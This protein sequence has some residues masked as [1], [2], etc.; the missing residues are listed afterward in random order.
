MFLE[1][2]N[3]PK[4]MTLGSAKNQEF[5]SKRILVAPLPLQGSLFSN[6]DS[7]WGDLL[8]SKVT[9]KSEFGLLFCKTFSS[10]SE[11]PSGGSPGYI[12]GISGIYPRDPWDISWG[13]L[14]VS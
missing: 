12:P 1:L 5:D 9:P 7:V 13:S 8:A 3:D 14:I 11:L 10:V 4:C 2:K 6:P